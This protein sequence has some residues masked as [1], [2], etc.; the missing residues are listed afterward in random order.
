M[1]LRVLGSRILVKEI[2]NKKE[3]KIIIPNKKEE[4][5]YKGIVIATGNGALLDN[6]NLMPMSIVVGET[7]IYQEYSGTPIKHEDEIYIIL[8]ERDVLAVMN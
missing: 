5:S 1:G 4:P 6:G 8:N 2:K 7:V 3:N